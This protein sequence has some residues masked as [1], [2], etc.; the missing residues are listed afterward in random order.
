MLELLLIVTV[1][2][3]LFIGFKKIIKMYELLKI[4][5]YLQTVLLSIILIVVYNLVILIKLPINIVVGILVVLC[6]VVTVYLAV[7]FQAYYYK[8]SDKYNEMVEKC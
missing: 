2:T 4:N 5:P 7:L 1:V 8:L 6:T 3:G